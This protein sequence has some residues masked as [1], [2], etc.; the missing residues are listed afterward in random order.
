VVLD[1]ARRQFPKFMEE[2]GENCIELIASKE[3]SFPKIRS[4]N[5]DPYNRLC[6]L[7]CDDMLNGAAS[8]IVNFLNIKA[9]ERILIRNYILSED[10]QFNF[11]KSIKGK[12]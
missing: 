7:I 2:F 5:K 8:H 6:S 4:L 1:L 9:S 3:H 11:E 12:F 10:V